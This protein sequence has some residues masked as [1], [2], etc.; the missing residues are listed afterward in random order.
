MFNKFLKLFKFLNVSI[1]LEPFITSI[2]CLEAQ[3]SINST[4]SFFLNIDL[5]FKT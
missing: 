2:E 3:F 4:M 1:E 5:K